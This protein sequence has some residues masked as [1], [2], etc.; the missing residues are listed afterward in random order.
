MKT[1]NQQDVKVEFKRKGKQKSKFCGLEKLP[2]G[3]DT[4]SFA[5]HIKLLKIEYKKVM[6]TFIIIFSI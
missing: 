3:E 5:R 1:S 4:T 6:V 2:A